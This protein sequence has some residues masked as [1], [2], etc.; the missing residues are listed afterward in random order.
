MSIV[1]THRAMA[2]GLPLLCLMS[3]L[4]LGACTSPGLP[5]DGRWVDLTHTF[6]DSTVVWPT[7]DHFD[8]E[9]ISYGLTAK[10][11]FYASNRFSTGEHGG[12]HV[13]APIH[14]A[15][16]GAT[17]DEIPVERLIGPAVVID[18]TLKSRADRDYQVTV[19]D[20]ADWEQRHGRIPRGALVFLRTGFSESWPDA[21]RYLGTAERGEQAVAQLHFP[22][23]H[24]DAARW[25]ATERHP[26]AVGIDTASIDFGQSTQYGSHVVLFQYEVPAFENVA[27]LGVLPVRGAWAVG[28][29]M[30]I[31]GGSGAPL[32][33]IAWLPE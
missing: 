19:T 3:L 4:V 2:R 5:T 25:L 28:L 31:G 29:P 23:L 7:S 10:G 22:G 1:S 32:R 15:E 26:G 17:V 14:F 24:P 12:T 18:V 30:K 6:D 20:L 13:D 16:G 9:V 8:L 11:Y 27:N 21:E 33:L